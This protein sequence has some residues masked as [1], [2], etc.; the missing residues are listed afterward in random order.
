MPDY[1]HLIDRVINTPLL[2]HPAKAE[3]V[4]AVLLRRAGVN[5]R[6]NTVQTNALEMGPLQQRRLVEGAGRPFLFDPNTG[7]AVVEVLGSLAHRQGYIGASSGVMGYDGIQAQYEAAL[8]S[9]EVRGILLDIHSPGGE[10]AGA[11][12]LADRIA[13]T[14]GLKPVIAIADDYAFSAAYLLAAA[15]DQVWLAGATSQVGSVGVVMVHFSFEEMIE[16]EGV[17]VTIIQAGARKTDG[18]PYQDLPDAVRERFQGAIDRIYGEFVARVA[19]WRGM[20]EAAVRGTEADIFMGRDAIKVGLATGMADPVELLAAL[21]EEVS[22]P[23]LRA[24]S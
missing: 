12:T 4:A 15:A 22:A 18:N 6:V 7:L 2:A 14:R 21:E 1:P 8:A 20:S 19:A 9:P 11:F 3:T 24:V 5:V 10:V 13:A 23:R 17:K 16:A